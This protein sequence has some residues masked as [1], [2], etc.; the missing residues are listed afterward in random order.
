MT[1]F[2]LLDVPLHVPKHRLETC[3][4]HLTQFHTFSKQEH[5]KLSYL[6]GITNHGLKE[7]QQNLFIRIPGI[8]STHFVD[9]VEEL[10][11]L[12]QL[13]D[14]GLYPRVI[15]AYT[16]GDLAGYKVEPFIEGE[17]LQ[18]DDFTKHQFAVL[19]TLKA[20]HDSNIQFANTYDIFEQLLSMCNALITR[21]HD[22]LPCLSHH[23]L[24]HMPIDSIQNKIYDL[25]TIRNQIFK[26]PSAFSPCHNDI[27][28]TNFIK[29][30]DPVDGRLY[31]LIDWEYAGMNDNMYDIAGIAAMLGVGLNKAH[32]FVLHYFNRKDTAR[33]AEEIK[34]VQFYM[35]LVKLYYAVWAALQVSTGNESASIEELK[36][37]WGPGSLSVFLDQYH[38]ENY[39]ALIKHHAI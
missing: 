18:F 25:Q 11:T 36:Q 16:E 29:L 4:K 1:V 33:Y 37:G 19:P 13:A 24:S 12:H 8:N 34:R 6:G 26:G 27:T 14:K 10:K 23:G 2:D 15:E 38:S 22:T 17:T 7:H 35:P 39:Q 28:P 32:H 30:K 31:Q 20:L 9:R 3:I 21:G 5:I